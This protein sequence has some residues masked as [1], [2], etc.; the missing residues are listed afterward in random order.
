M[1]TPIQ[2]EILQDYRAERRFGLDPFSASRIVR[3]MH[4]SAIA[5]GVE[6]GYK[7]SRDT[8]DRFRVADQ[9]V[10]TVLT[11]EDRRGNREAHRALGLLRTLRD[12]NRQAV[13]S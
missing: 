8:A 5:R 7:T 6:R 2:Q 1:R 12:A 10:A 3:D 11:Q 9:W 4:A 13:A